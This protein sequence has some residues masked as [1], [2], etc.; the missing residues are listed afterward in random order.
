VVRWWDVAGR[1]LRTSWA[2]ERGGVRALAFAPDGRSLVTSSSRYAAAPSVVQFWDM[3]G[4]E[5]LRLKGGARQIRALSFAT[6]HGRRLAAA[7]FDGTVV[8]WE[9]A[10]RRQ[11]D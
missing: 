5:R 6:A 3:S 11:G 8:I 1:E 9:G 2:V 4:E 7:G 10:T